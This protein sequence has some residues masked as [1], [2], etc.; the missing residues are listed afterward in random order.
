MSIESSKIEGVLG[1]VLAGGASRRMGQDKAL[2][3]VG[4]QTLIG[5]AVAVLEAVLGEVVI[6]A[7][8][9]QR[10]GDLGVEV[11]PDCRPGQGPIGGIHTALVHGAGRAVFVLACDMPYVTSELVRWISGSRVGTQGR[12]VAGVPAEGAHVRV[13]RDRHGP[14]PLC[15]LYSCGCLPTVERA[16]NREAL[17]ALELLEH[18]ETA[19]LD[20]DPGAVWYS[21]RLLTN[22]NSPQDFV[23]I[24]ETPGPDS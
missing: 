18:L 24:I 16:L 8:Q 21:P 20:L 12:A 5:R 2:L 19:Y 6:V 10:Y 17:S 14:Q 22:V 13:V 15:G 9:Q 7:P 1:A 4:G 3:E 23:N 11:V